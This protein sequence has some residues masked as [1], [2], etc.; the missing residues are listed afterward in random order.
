[1]ENIKRRIALK[2]AYDGT[3]YAGWQ[4]QEN[5]IGIQAVLEDTISRQFGEPVHVMGSG[6]TDAGVHAE[7]QVAAFDF[8]HPI[9]AESLIRALNANLPDD[10]RIL[11]AMDVAASFQ[12][13]Y[14][15]KKK[16]YGYR[17]LYGPVMLPHLRYTSI[18]VP[19]KLDIEKMR[20]SLLPLSGEHDFRAFR[21]A[22]AE[23]AS[24]VRTI[25]EVSLEEAEDL[26][27]NGRLLEI[28]VC[29]NGFLYNMVRIIAGTALDIGRGKLDPSAFNDALESGERNYLG[30]TAPP[31]GLRLLSVEY[32]D[33][34]AWPKERLR[35]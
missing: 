30:V 27:E 18:L 26:R 29:G 4:R 15:A 1:M 3:Q 17:F 23:N 8:H 31:Q 12:P 5:G 16:T 10:I 21:S 2:I 28:R 34:P 20:E 14:G 32:D 22:K 6:R 19:E 35:K 9:A 33:L 11:D 25:Y 24:T 7:G 13:Q